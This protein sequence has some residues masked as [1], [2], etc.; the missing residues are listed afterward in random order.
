MH[1]DLTDLPEESPVPGRRDYEWTVDTLRINSPAYKIWGSSPSDVW[2]INSSDF[3]NSIYH[4]DGNNWTTDENFRL[5]VPYSIYGFA[6][7]NIFIGGS[8]GQI[9]HF[10]GSVWQVTAVL[11]KDGNDDIVFDNI[12]GESSYDFYAFGAYPDESGY[13]NNS[14]IAHYFYGKWEMLNTDELFGIVE[15]LY[16]NFKDNKIYL[17]VIGGHD[18]TD[19]T[20][21]FE[22]SQGKYY[23]LYSNIWTKGLQ[24]DISIIN[25]EVYFILGNEISK[26][27]DNQFQTVI[28]VANPNFYQRIWGRNSKDIFLLMT[29]GLVH[30]NGSDMEYLFYFSQPNS[31]PWTQIYGAAI[32]DKEIFFT[33][34]EPPTNLSLIYHGKLN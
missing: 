11:T 7:N 24:A 29:D 33:V 4:Y 22:F 28:K 1:C 30:Y 12:W 13:A 2:S 8:D 10:D 3:N 27:I 14:V 16:K 32:F 6:N 23:K 18:Y 5:L 20:H 15:H 17:Q 9:W 34:D 26:R 25:K 31:K 21:I 19:S